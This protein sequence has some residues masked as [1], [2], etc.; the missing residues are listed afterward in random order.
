MIPLDYS[1][2]VLQRSISLLWYSLGLTSVLC[3]LL[4]VLYLFWLAHVLIYGSLPYSLP[5]AYLLFHCDNVMLHT[6]GFV[7]F[8]LYA[9]FK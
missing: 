1:I 9:H 4:V 7:L 8:G 3:V 2:S 6:V 5:L